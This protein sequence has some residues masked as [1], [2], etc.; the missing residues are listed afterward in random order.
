LSVAGIGF[1]KHHASAF[2]RASEGYLELERENDN[3][4]DENAIKIIGCYKG[5]FSTKRRMLGY[6]PKETSARI[7]KNGFWDQV[8]PRLLMTYLG[9]DDY[10]EILFQII[11]PKKEMKRFFQSC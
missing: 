8:K 1:R 10:V 4:H 11:G 7:V 9:R 2:I 6:V 3:P 5:F